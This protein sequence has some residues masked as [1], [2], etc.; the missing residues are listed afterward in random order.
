MQFILDDVLPSRFK[1]IILIDVDIRFRSDVSNLY[2]YFNEMS[3]TEKVGIAKDWGDMTIETAW[4]RGRTPRGLQ[5]GEPYPSTQ[6]MNSGVVLLDL[7]KIRNKN[8]S[9]LSLFNSEKIRNYI[10]EFNI[11]TWGD[12][13]I[14][15]LIRWKELNQVYVLPCVYNYQTLVPK[16]QWNEWADEPM[17]LPNCQGC[18]I[19]EYHFC[20]GKPQI[21]Q[22]NHD[23]EFIDQ[24]PVLFSYNNIFKLSTWCDDSQWT[25]CF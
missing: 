5:I 19:E 22:I 23:R 13:I 6:H 16:Y 4:Y 12:Q 3:S 9:N 20:P 21:E 15:T 11:P 18:K 2:N 24:Y 7:E 25:H 17:E 10:K 1:R 14:Y 8:N